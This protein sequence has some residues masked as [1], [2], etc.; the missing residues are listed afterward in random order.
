MI[1]IFKFLFRFYFEMAALDEKYLVFRLY[2]QLK[3]KWV[4]LIKNDVH[5]KVVVTYIQV[6]QCVALSMGTKQSYYFN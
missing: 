5:D 4:C 6:Q 1:T 3:A 2:V